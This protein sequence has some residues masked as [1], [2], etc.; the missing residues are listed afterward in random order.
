MIFN[1][2]FITINHEIIDFARSSSAG[3]GAAGQL[4]DRL[5][6]ASSTAYNASLL[7][8]FFDHRQAHVQ[9]LSQKGSILPEEKR[10]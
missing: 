5:S 7:P 2:V 8:L 9:C 10:T 1:S 6:T 3:R 4:G